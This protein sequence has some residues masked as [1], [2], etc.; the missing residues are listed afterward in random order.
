MSTQRTEE[1]SELKVIAYMKGYDESEVVAKKKTPGLQG[2]AVAA[3]TAWLDLI[4]ATVIVCTWHPW[5]KSKIE[6]FLARLV[7]AM[8]P[9]IGFGMI[10]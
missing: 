8:P 2:D 10:L 7:D 3:M 1:D 4:D 5:S 9:A 6:N